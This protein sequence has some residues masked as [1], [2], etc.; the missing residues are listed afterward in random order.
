MNGQQITKTKYDSCDAQH[1]KGMLSAEKKTCKKKLYDWSPIFSKAVEVK[2]FW[3]IVLLLRRN[4]VRPNTKL[5][6]WALSLNIGDIQAIPEETIKAELRLAQK[7]LRGVKEKAK[8]Y[9]EQHLRDLIVEA[10]VNDDDKMHERRLQILLRAHT[11]Q[12]AFK[13]IQ[14]ILRPTTRGGL[15]YVMVPEN[16]NP[17]D[18]PYDPE[19]VKNWEMI[20]DQQ[21]LQEFLLKRNIVHFQQAHGTPFTTEP[22]VKLDWNASSSEANAI[23]HGQI[24]TEFQNSNPY[25]MEILHHIANCEQLPEI[26]TYLSPNEIAQGF[27][28]WKETTST[29][30]S[31]CHL[32]L[33]R[34]P[35]IPIN[36]EEKEKIRSGILGIQ[37]HIIN[38]PTSQG[39]SPK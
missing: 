10:S 30:P 32:G 20:H 37:T 7:Q 14:Q 5:K 17:E 33:R 22:L 19:K 11:Q 6:T 1:I 35:T 24:P 27:R 9:C 36:N 12:R 29:S 34:I 26:D 31:G 21:R 8:E 25:V 39:S 23:L 18:Y 3:K 28:Q 16:S 2:A 13:R 38:I 15:S 4:R